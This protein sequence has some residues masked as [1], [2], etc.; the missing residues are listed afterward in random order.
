MPVPGGGVAVGL[1][2]FGGRVAVVAS[3]VRRAGHA[4]G[5]DPISGAFRA[6]RSAVPISDAV[7]LARAD[8]TRTV[9]RVAVGLAFFA[10]HAL[11]V[12]HNPRTRFAEVALPKTGAA[13]RV[14]EAGHTG[15]AVFTGRIGAAIGTRRPV[16]VIVQVAGLPWLSGLP[17]ARVG[18]FVAVPRAAVGIVALAAYLAAFAFLIFR[19]PL[20]KII[21]FAAWSRNTITLPLNIRVAGARPVP[22]LAIIVTNGSAAVFAVDE[23]F[24]GVGGADPLLADISRAPV[25][26]NENYRFIK[27]RLVFRGKLIL[28]EISNHFYFME[29]YIFSP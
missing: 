26:L 19:H 1:A 13:A 7:A 14:G 27:E 23:H 17:F 25:G 8:V 2:F 3:P 16:I 29:K 12:D 15:P 22:T 4:V 18:A 6:A 11:A 21:V 10:G 28:I 20:E 9:G 24:R 5:A